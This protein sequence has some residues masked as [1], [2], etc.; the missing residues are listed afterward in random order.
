M[1]DRVLLNLKKNKLDVYLR[2]PSEHKTGTP[3]RRRKN[4]EIF[5]CLIP[6]RPRSQIIYIGDI[7]LDRS[8]HTK[9]IDNK[10]TLPTPDLIL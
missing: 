2:K 9:C 3:Q 1:Q 8:T 4:Q 6:H 10:A 5:A 7:I